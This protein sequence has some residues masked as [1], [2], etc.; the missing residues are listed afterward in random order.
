MKKVIR[1]ICWFRSIRAVQIGPEPNLRLDPESRGTRLQSP[2][3]Q[4]KKEH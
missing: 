4:G 1:N 3:G 2:N